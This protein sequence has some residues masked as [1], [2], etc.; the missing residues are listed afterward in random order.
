MPAGGT[1]GTLLDI[2][3]LEAFVAVAEELHFSRAAERLHIAQPPL[4]YRIQQLEKQL[5]VKLF[6]RSTRLVTL[7]EAGECL[8]GPARKVLAA[9]EAAETS[10]SAFNAGLSGRVRLGF[11]GASTSKVLPALAQEVR[12]RYPGI[13][14]RL[15]GQVYADAALE[16]V[17][18]GQL[19]MGFVRLPIHRPGVSYRVI[20]HERLVC[21]LPSSH[22]L[23]GAREVRLED[24]ADEAVIS[25][26]AGGGSSLRTA[27]LDAFGRA[28]VTPRIVQEAPDS[29]T[30]LALVAAGAGLTL[31]LTSVQHVQSA[32]VAYVPIAGDPVVLHAA[33]AWRTDDESAAIARIL[34]VCDDVL[35]DLGMDEPT[36]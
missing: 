20:E 18:N 27:L 21:A 10:V 28:G 14:L 25:F 3:E 7:T 32:G 19:D 17:A 9:V 33:L 5:K 24:L 2:K 30:I 4:S 31:T 16:Q 1:K 26:P 11:A 35:P 6:N 22:P 23:A 12:R 29:Y 34:E 13:D 36:P 15:Q 8:L